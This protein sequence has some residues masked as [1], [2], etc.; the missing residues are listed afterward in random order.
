MQKPRLI[1]VH[2]FHLRTPIG[3][4]PPPRAPLLLVLATYRFM[5]RHPSSLLRQ[6]ALQLRSNDDTAQIQQLKGFH[7]SYVMFKDVPI[8]CDV[9][10]GIPRSIVPTD[11]IHGGTRAVSHRNQRDTAINHQTVVMV[12]DSSRCEPE[13]QR[14]FSQ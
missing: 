13:V 8:L 12:A 2:S 3:A 5:T 14:V 7:F 10:T 11:W 4:S 6:R 9:S 1:L